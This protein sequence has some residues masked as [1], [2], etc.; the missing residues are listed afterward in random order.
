MIAEKN[1][2]SRSIKRGWKIHIPKWYNTNL[3]DAK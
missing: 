1:I 3:D 2:R